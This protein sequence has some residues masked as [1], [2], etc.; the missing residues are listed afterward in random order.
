MDRGQ[1][2]Q[3]LTIFALGSLQIARGDHQVTGLASRKAAALLVYLACDPRPHPREVLADLFWDKRTQSQAMANLRVVLSSLNKHLGTYVSIERDTVALKPMTAFWLDAAEL[4]SALTAPAWDFTA[5]EAALELYR[6]AFLE[7]FYLREASGFEAWQLRERERLHRLAI[8]GLQKLVE[9]ELGQGRYKAGISHANR[10]LALDPLQETAHR[11]LM[12]LLALSG[13]REQALAQYESCRQLLSAE[14]GIEPSNMTAAVHEAIAADQLGQPLSG[15]PSVAAIS[16]APVP[17]FLLDKHPAERPPPPFVARA[18]ELD[19]LDEQLTFS[20]ADGARAVFVAGEA[21]SGKTALLSEYV[22]R[23]QENHDTLLVAWGNGHTRAGRGDP[24]VPFRELLSMLAGDVETHW[25]AGVAHTEQARRLWRALPLT[26]SLLVEK[27]PALLDVFVPARALA[28]RLKAVEIDAG[29]FGELQAR[30]EQWGGAGDLE[31]EQLFEQVAMVLRGLSARWP[32]MLILDDLHLADKASTDLLFYLSRRLAGAP[33]LLVGA[34]RA[35]EVAR[36]RRGQRHPLQTVLNASKRAFG[37]TILDL[38]KADGRDFVRQLLDSEPNSLTDE[39]RHALWTWTEGQP[40]FTVELLRDMQERGDL[41]R[42]A[43]GRWAVQPGMVWERL[44]ARVEAVIDERIDRLDEDLAA[45]LIVAA[46]EG[47]R[48][49]AQV[50]AMVRGV[51]QLE[52]V[53]QLSHHLEREHRLVLEQRGRQVAG[54]RL[55]RYRFWHRLFQE[56]VYRKLGRMERTLLHREVGSALAS[57]YAADPSAYFG[58]LGYHAEQAGQRNTAADWYLKAAARAR[59]HG[60]MSEA[61]DYY[62]SA[63][64]NIP[65]ADTLRRW[66]ALAGHYRTSEILSDAKAAADDVAELLRLAADRDDPRLIAE[67]HLH[68][69][70]HAQ[71]TGDDHLA[72]DALALALK[73]AKDGENTRL[74]T[75]LMGMSI[76]SLARLGDLAGAIAI[77]EAALSTAEAL[78]DEDLLSRTLNNLA[79]CAMQVG[80]YSRAAELLARQVAI[81]RSLGDLTLEAF[82]LLNLA[83]NQLQVGAWTLAAETA[84]QSLALSKSLGALRLQAYNHLHLCLAHFRLGDLDQAQ[85]DLEAAWPL[86]AEVDDNFG[87]AVSHSYLGLVLEADGMV[88]LAAAAFD[89]A[90]QQLEAMGAAA[91]AAD[92]LAGLIRCALAAADVTQAARL[93]PRLWHYLDV[94]SA[95]G[96]EFPMWAFLT[97]AHAF[98]TMGDASKA[99][100]IAERGCQELRKRAERIADSEWRRAYLEELVEHKSL[101]AMVDARSS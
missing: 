61:Q 80:D 89:R 32:L 20:L 2:S 40:L 76:T 81:G 74:E 71:W 92:A 97:C 38:D 7:G 18:S 56:R 54:Q 72:L 64:D 66:P 44:P 8:G 5:V 51:P 78:G 101:M 87:S 95:D 3:K 93:A 50:V 91:P 79:N 60:A 52:L 77:G 37:D 88:R 12:T 69:A 35:E 94:H 85:E 42:D 99:D 4:E 59:G 36:G 67:A 62:Q 48:F 47:E 21:G 68:Q 53:H 58:E 33:I 13:Q 86:L 24:Y 22:R 9:W 31:R 11:Q 70:S 65:I 73:A 19:W 34:Y 28:A 82:G 1:R 43:A 14:L 90:R 16:A 84:R 96:L 15:K 6:G 25:T 55:F 63:L 100:L 29:W 57:L 39:F 75:Q 98:A 26:T 30:L 17:G 83:Y 41:R 45:T 23:V 49:T 46:V 27:G 10:L